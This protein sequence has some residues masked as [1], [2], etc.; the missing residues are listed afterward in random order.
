MAAKGAKRLGLAHAQAGIRRSDALL[1]EEFDA[2]WAGLWPQERFLVSL[3]AS[4]WGTDPVQVVDIEAAM[5][6]GQPRLHLVRN[7]LI[8]HHGLLSSPRRGELGVARPQFAEWVANAHPAG[9]RAET[10]T[11]LNEGAPLS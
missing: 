8:Y 3:L 11:P 5:K 10:R 1:G 6:P 7:R 4:R 9:G 2:I